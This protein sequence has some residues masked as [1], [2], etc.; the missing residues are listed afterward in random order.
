M[1]M[2]KYDL[3]V[4]GGE[5]I[6]PGQDL[7][8]LKDVAVAGGRIASVEE[9]IP[10]SRAQRVIGAAG[11]IVTPGLID[12]HTHVYWGATPISVEADAVAATS[13]VTTFV[14]AGSSGAASFAGFRRHI[15]ERSRSRIL[16]F[17]NI[18]S[19]GLI[20]A[21]D[22]G[23]CEEIRLLDPAGALRT[24]EAHHPLIHG[25]KVRVERSSVGGN[26]VEPLRLAREVAD[27]TDV[28]LMV[29][30]GAP[31]PTLG[32]VLPLLRRGDILTHTFTGHGATILDRSGQVRADVISA[33]E[34]GISIDVGHGATGCDVEVAARALER[35][36]GPDTISTDL[37]RRVVDGPVLDLPATMS[38]YLAL[39]L[40]LTEVIRATTARPAQILGLE[41]H[42]G[43]LHPGAIADIS[44]FE[45]Q[46]GSFTFTDS[47]G[48]SLTGNQRIRHV[49]TVCRGRVMER[50]KQ[51]TGG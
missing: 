31:P 24:I 30:F 23:E 20:S 11:R 21:P 9:G 41:Q 16:P 44:L 18:S 36:F 26:G 1:P 28:P 39:G 47:E 3:L 40:T 10:V 43:T 35:S 50:E 46:G 15:I 32:Q 12:M 4:K 6:D 49:L 2:A 45:L 19:I 48:K 27:D 38:K 17:L 22:V 33:R 13:G 8:A 14:D 51:E 7:H 25:I 34:R 37:H 42:A 29:Q 5:I